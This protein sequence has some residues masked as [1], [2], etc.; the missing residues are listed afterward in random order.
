MRKLRHSSNR[1]FDDQFDS[2]I[3]A[4]RELA[5]LIALKLIEIGAITLLWGIMFERFVGFDRF[6]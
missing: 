4:I 1:W 3:H 6:F 5:V 2:L